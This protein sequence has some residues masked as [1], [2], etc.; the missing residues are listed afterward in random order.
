MNL[1]GRVLARAAV[2]GA[3]KEGVTEVRRLVVREGTQLGAITVDDH[4]TVAKRKR[5][6]AAR[7]DQDSHDREEEVVGYRPGEARCIDAHFAGENT[8]TRENVLPDLFEE[9]SHLQ[10]RAEQPGRGLN[11]QARP[12]LG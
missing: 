7:G 9:V 2:R 10:A 3:W 12:N 6:R 1:E 8:E 5:R 11:Q 4:E